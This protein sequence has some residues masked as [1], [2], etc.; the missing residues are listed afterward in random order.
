M[1]IIAR[2]NGSSTGERNFINQATLSSRSVVKVAKNYSAS[3]QRE[4]DAVNGVLSIPGRAFQRNFCML[5][6][7]WEMF[8]RENYAVGQCGDCLLSRY[9][10]KYSQNPTSPKLSACKLS[11]A[12][13]CVR[14]A[15]KGKCLNQQCWSIRAKFNMRK[16][17]LTTE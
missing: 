14:Q 6:C 1:E 9:L 16:L 17:I 3:F 8:S 5:V 15:C 11:S 4:I 2:A 13:I 7:A 12:A 10:V